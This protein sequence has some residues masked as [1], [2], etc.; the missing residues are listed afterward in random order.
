MA[1]ISV[2]HRHQKVLLSL[3]ALA[4][5]KFLVAYSREPSEIKALDPFV[6]EN[7]AEANRDLGTE[8]KRNRLVQE[9]L[10]KI[11]CHVQDVVPGETIAKYMPTLG[12]IEALL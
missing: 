5:C 12:D 8:N 1:N 9:S 4:K 2:L 7:L 3:K 11:I 10:F 6:P